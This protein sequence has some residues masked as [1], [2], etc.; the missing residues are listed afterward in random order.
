[1]KMQNCAIQF[2]WIH[3]QNILVPKTHGTLETRGKKTLFKG[4]KIRKFT[5]RL[6][7]LVMSKVALTNKTMTAQG[8]NKE[9][10]NRHANIEGESPGGLIPTQRTTLR[11]GEIDSPRKE[12]TNYPIPNGYH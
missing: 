1:M 4:Q 9:D 6:C 11:A 3:L 8:V 10:N 5:V 7:L 12:Q 2:Q